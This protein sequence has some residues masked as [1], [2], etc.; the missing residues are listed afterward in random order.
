MEVKKIIENL[1]NGNYKV[2]LESDCGCS[3]DWAINQNNELSC[4]DASSYDACWIGKILY[5]NGVDEP[6]AEYLYGEYLKILAPELSEEDLPENVLDEM[7]AGG[8]EWPENEDHEA[9]ERKSLIA[10]LEDHI[11]KGGKLYRDNENGF[12][13][14]YACIL[15]L[16]DSDEEINEDWD[17]L[18]PEEWA[19]EFLYEGDAATES[20]ASHRII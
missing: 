2:K 18:D 14:Q 15:V 5:V 17:E 1:Q 19:S 20:F 11:A 6:I 16:P 8:N 4:D 12:S 3:I 7:N 13:N 9:K 10:Y